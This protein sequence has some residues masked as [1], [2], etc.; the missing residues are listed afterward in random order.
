MYP[1]PFE[2]GA[3]VR[4]RYEFPDFTSSL[5]E[6]IPENLLEMRQYLSIIYGLTTAS[7]A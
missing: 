7:L 2:R 1:P 3:L 6:K 5:I 4:R